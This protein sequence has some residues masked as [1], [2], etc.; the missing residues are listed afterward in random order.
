[1]VVRI[2]PF[3]FDGVFYLMRTDNNFKKIESDFYETWKTRAI[4]L[5][6]IG[7]TYSEYLNSE[8]WKKVKDKASKRKVYQ[9]CEI[10]KS[11]QN[12]NLHHKH[13]RFLMHI[14]ELHSIIALCEPCH[15]KVHDLARAKNKS[16]REATLILIRSVDK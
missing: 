9:S 13:Y 11:K 5:S 1:M 16:V 4:V 3:P 12:I 2:A 8:H 10:C 14:H 6:E 15:N 7:M